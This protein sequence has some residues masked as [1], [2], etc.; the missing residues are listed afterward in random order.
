MDMY[1]QWSVNYDLGRNHPAGHTEDDQVLADVQVRNDMI[2]LHLPHAI[3]SSAR[4]IAYS[5]QLYYCLIVGIILLLF[6]R[7][8]TA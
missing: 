1:T 8:M 7:S 5:S 3:S 6:Q 2:H 4:L